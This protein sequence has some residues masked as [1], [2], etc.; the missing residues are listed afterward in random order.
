MDPAGLVGFSCDAER[1]DFPWRVKQRRADEHLRRL[2]AECDDYL[3][4]A[5]V[6][7]RHEA[8]QQS[9]TLRVWLHA[10]A[11]PP[12]AL[13]ATI[14]DVLHN[15]RSALESVAWAACHAGPLTEEQE[16][17]VHFP[18]VRDC[19]D[20]WSAKGALFNV[21]D[22]HR[23]VFRQ[24]QPWFWDE[25]ARKMG[26]DVAPDPDRHPLVRLHKMAIDDRHRLPH[27]VLALAGDTYL[28]TNETV[29]VQAIARGGR[30]ARPGDE[31]I[32]WRVDPPDAVT[33]VHPGGDP[34]LAL[35]EEAAFHRRSALDELR[36]MRD[37]VVQATRRVEIDVLGAVPVADLEG[38]A[39]LNRAFIEAETGLR[40][41][42]SADHI[43]DSD[44]LERY[45]QAQEAEQAA[46]AYYLQRWHE[47]F[48]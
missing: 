33:D 32:E 43:I 10:D 38:L 23:D 3:R 12:A 8:D 29:N 16:A 17:C 15:L 36:R 47:L 34:I 20:W 1:V 19:K 7:F 13:S 37:T 14:G 26:L 6:G 24:L 41:V 11:D 4:T 40:L 35:S 39:E 2:E 21:S 9:G 45:G 31:V 27:V 30:L 42:E 18:I 28:T 48:D 25:E 46:R 5:H 22:S 44:Y